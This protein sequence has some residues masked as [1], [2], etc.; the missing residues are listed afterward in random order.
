MGTID[1]ISGLKNGQYL[2]NSR[3]KMGQFWQNLRAKDRSIPEEY[4]YRKS[5]K[6]LENIMISFTSKLQMI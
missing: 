2:E 3:A 4:H 6:I 5:P 1:R